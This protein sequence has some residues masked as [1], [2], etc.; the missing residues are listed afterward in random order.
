MEVEGFLSVLVSPWD[1]LEEVNQVVGDVVSTAH[2]CGTRAAVALGARPTTSSLL[3]SAR[4]AV[5]SR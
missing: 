4:S 1:P 5:A 2:R 3:S